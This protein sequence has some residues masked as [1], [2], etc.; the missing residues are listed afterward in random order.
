M[1][2][3]IGFAVFGLLAVSVL[4][5]KER[6]CIVVSLDAQRVYALEG[7]TLV[8]EL[9]CSTGRTGRETPVGRFQ[10]A[11]QL[12][13]NRALPELGGAAIPFTLRVP[14]YDPKQRRTRRINF[15]QYHHVP[16]K[17]VSN[18][19]IRLKEG[20]AERL[21]YWVRVGTPVIVQKEPLKN[22]VS[23]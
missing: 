7:Q 10:V 3:I 11:A 20:D 17:P 19:C 23:R 21:F 16:A 2:T 6:K 12:R 18:G 22:Q 15:H 5:Q 1:E 14:M 13:Y 8:F 4:P 9:K